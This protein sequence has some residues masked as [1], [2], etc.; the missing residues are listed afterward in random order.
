M[1]RQANPFATDPTPATKPVIWQPSVAKQKGETKHAALTERIIADID[2]G[3]LKP[4]DRM[5]T[6]R[7][8]ARELGL[9][10]QTVSLS[11]KEAE[12]L[13]YLS[14]EIGRGTFVK[15]RVTDR[16]GRMMLDHSQNEV[17]DLSIIR[18]VYLDAHE[19][20][21]REI[22][23]ELA[24]SDIASFMRPCRPIAGLDRHRETA[25]LW[26]QP[27]GVSAGAGR[28]L[29]TNGAAHSIF[30]ALSC[31]IRSGDVVLCENLTDHGI[32]GLSNILGFSL[33]G[34]PT[35]AEGILPDALEAACALGSVR[36][37][38]LIPTLNNPTSHVAGTERR[39]AIAEIAQRYSIFVIEDEVYRPMIEED[40]P[41]ITEL[42][43]DLGFFATSFTKTVL[44]GLRVG[45]LVVPP[46]YSIRAAS[47]LRVSSWSGTYLTA[48]IA[49]RWVENGT[50]QELLA[51]QRNEAR[52]RQGIAAEILGDHFASS[53]PLSLC[54]WLKVPQHWTEDGLVRSLANQ[55]VAVT[56]SEPFIAGP[57]HGGG[58]RICLGGRMRHATLRKALTTVRQA[59]EQLPPVYDVGS[60]G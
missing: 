24:D 49:T 11:Y 42:L 43:P 15:A 31:I 59:F 58:I 5:P 46:A 27:M 13:G 3:I 57:G 45:Y 60:I 16:A 47:I 36:A 30:L 55:N 18:A 21:S 39:R 19:D 10:V 22:F 51:I 41:S 56:P 23:R 35:D 38:V 33:K 8:L 50:A 1:R 12:R 48:E 40:L 7:D 54:A 9:S 29:V 26:L 14:G 2:S 17:L 44:T 32:I 20:A 52:S 25:R 28:I 6:H 53:H 4:M 37:L 34:L